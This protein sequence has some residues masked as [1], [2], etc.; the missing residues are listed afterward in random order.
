LTHYR[1]LETFDENALLEVYPQ[2]GRTHQIR[3]H[4]AWLKHPIVGDKVY[5]YR[6]QRIRMKHL[7][8]HAASLTVRSPSSEERLTFEA[9]LPPALEH[10]LTHLRKRPL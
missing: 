9:P 6:K 5:G 2:T 1:V 3:V 4:L 7:W 10:V 8:L